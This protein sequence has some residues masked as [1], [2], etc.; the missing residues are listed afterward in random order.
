MIN[1][2]FILIEECG[3][4]KAYYSGTMIEAYDI[5]DAKHPVT[6]PYVCLQ[7][8]NSDVSCKFWDYGEGYCRLSSDSGNGPKLVPKIRAMPN[9]R[10]GRD[11][12]VDDF[13]YGARKCKFKFPLGIYEKLR[14]IIVDNI[15]NDNTMNSSLY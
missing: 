2:S 9:A 6:H 13:D 15:K 1:N 12:A 7:K 5:K 11:A 8:C 14:M 4:G 10:R 3:I